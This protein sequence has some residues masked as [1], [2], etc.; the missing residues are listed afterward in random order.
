MALLVIEEIMYHPEEIEDHDRKHIGE[1]LSYASW[2]TLNRQPEPSPGVCR[3][4]RFH[5]PNHHSPRT[6]TVV[7]FDPD[8]ADALRKFRIYNF[9][10]PM[11]KPTIPAIFRSGARWG[12][13]PDERHQRFPA[14]YSDLTA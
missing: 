8:N 11:F 2:I 14:C 12:E 9:T 3:L 7:P 10:D 4:Y 6:P 1:Y 5:L 13:L